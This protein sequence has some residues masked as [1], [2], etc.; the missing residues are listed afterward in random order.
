MTDI[1]LYEYAPTRSL[2]CRWIL[3]EAGLE[4]ES[5]GNAPEIIH[6]QELCEVQPLGKL[7]AA[8][9]DGRNLF[10]S[11]AIVAAIADRV[12]EK[13]LIARPGTFERSRYDQWSFFATSEI[14]SWAWCALLN[15]HEFLQS[16]EEHVPEIIPQMKKHFQLGAQAVEDHLAD[17]S[18]MVEDRFSATDINVG[19]AVHLGQ[20]AGFLEDRFVNLQ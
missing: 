20:F 18:F 14:E 3:N 8:I 10:E 16:K 11:S 13:H 1:K 12:P 15:T 2:K 7:P 9:I 6:S 4:Y 19:Y 5:R 17:H